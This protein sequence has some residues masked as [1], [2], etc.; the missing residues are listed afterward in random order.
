MGIQNKKR[1]MHQGDYR[2]ITWGV[3]RGEGRVFISLLSSQTQ[4]HFFFTSAKVEIFF[5]KLQKRWDYK[6]Q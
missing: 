2:V 3:E 6:P 4:T 1:K 5:I